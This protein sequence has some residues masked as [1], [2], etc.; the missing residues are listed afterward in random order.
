M[1]PSAPTQATRKLWFLLAIAIVLIAGGLALHFKRLHQADSSPP[2]EHAPWALQTGIVERGGVASGIQSVAVVEASQDIV[3]SPQIQGMVLAVGPRA[4]VAVKRG[5]LLVRIDSRAIGH[6][7]VA[8]QQQRT[9][10]LADADYAAKQQARI[11]A[12]LAEGGVSQAQAD[13]ARAAAAG[14][15]AKA[16]ALADQIAALRVSLDYAEIRAPQ[17]AVVA[18][19]MIEVGNTVGPGKPVYRLIAG[20]GAVVRVSLT[21]ADL[22]HVHVGDTL[23]L[24]Q[25]TATLRLPI[26]R[27]APAVNAAGLGTVEADAVAAP[28]G[29]PSGSTVTATVHT[30]ASDENLTVP[31]AALVGSGT[32]AHV[33]AFAPAKQAGEPGRLHLV[34]VAVLQQGSARAAVRGVL[35]PGESVVVGQTA[36]LAQ[37]REGDAAVTAASVGAGR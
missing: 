7:V 27:V 5:R 29:L 35:T 18:E 36:V 16:Q 33:V 21:A 25:A 34:S 31:A 20:K 3:L 8:L 12:V 26:T 28:F 22:A 2:P 23:E 9:A 6:D 19:R 11:D 37:L 17:D 15:R 1:K 13:Q 4:G 32:G 10:A 30:A 14:A 24:Q